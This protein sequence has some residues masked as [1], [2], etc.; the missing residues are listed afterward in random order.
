MSPQNI[1]VIEIHANAAR[2]LMR[3]NIFKKQYPFNHIF[4]D[5]LSLRLQN[6][7]QQVSRNGKTVAGAFL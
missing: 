2:Q 6:P 1:N 5:D 4:A 3:N 7:Q